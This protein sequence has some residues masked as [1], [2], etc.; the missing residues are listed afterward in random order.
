[1]TRCAP[2]PSGCVISSQFDARDQ[3]LDA[4]THTFLSVLLFNL[5]TYLFICLFVYSLR[6]KVSPAAILEYYSS[7]SFSILGAA[8]LVLVALICAQ[9]V[10]PSGLVRSAN[11]K[12]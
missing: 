12:G 10:S 2:G 7:W 4:H 1:M 6:V 11:R 5:F 8:A 9:F 3:N